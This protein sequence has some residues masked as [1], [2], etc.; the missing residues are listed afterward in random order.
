MLNYTFSNVGGSGSERNSL[1]KRSGFNITIPTDF[2]PLA[3]Q[4]SIAVQSFWITVLG[5]EG[6]LI[7]NNFGVNAV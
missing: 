7:F 2:H 3:Y 4:Q 5:T 1:H 6:G